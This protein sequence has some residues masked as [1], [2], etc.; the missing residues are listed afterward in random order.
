MLRLQSIIYYFSVFALASIL[1]ACKSK[2]EVIKP[3]EAPPTVVDVIIASPQT[4]SNVIEANGTV[5]ANEYTELHPEVSGRL[6]YLNVQEGNHVAQGTVI[7][8][9]NDADLV[10]QA[11]KSKVQLELAQQTEERLKKLLDVNGVN[12]SD[13]DAA[14]NQVNSLKAD[15]AYTQTLIDKTVIKAPFSGVLGLRQV[16]PGAY[17]SPSTIIASIQQFDKVK[18]DFTL[19]EQYS[20]IIKKGNTVD[21]QVDAVGG[22]KKKATIIA[23][24]P[25]INQSSRN[26]MVRTILQDG[27]ANPGAFVKVY[28]QADV[29]KKAIMVPSNSVIPDDKNNQL[30][31]VKGGKASFVNVQ[32]GL[33]QASNVEIVSGVNPGDT[34]VV[35]GVLFARPK[36]SLKIKSVKTLD[37]LDKQ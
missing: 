24:E 25:Q 1:F 22:T 14:L 11:Q 34:V 5:V 20:N 36:G 6:T 19:P 3:K 4:I 12:Q 26:L 27:T 21:V 18:V 30:V 17:V 7:A 2:P 8:R 9:I 31:L 29:N 15:I 37:Q 23:I 33:R 28:V 16:S 32:T 13:Y 10:A 35:T